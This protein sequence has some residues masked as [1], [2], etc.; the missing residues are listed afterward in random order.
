M[1]NRAITDS[2]SY[3]E[4]RGKQQSVRKVFEFCLERLNAPPKLQTEIL[5]RLG[6]LEARDQRTLRERLR[7][8]E[9]AATAAQHIKVAWVDLGDWRRGLGVDGWIEQLKGDGGLSTLRLPGSVEALERVVRQADKRQ[10]LK[11]KRRIG[12]I[13][14]RSETGRPRGGQQTRVSADDQ[15]R[16]ADQALTLYKALRPVV[17]MR[18]FTSEQK[19]RR[20]ILTLLQSHQ[21]P[22]ADLEVDR[23][24]RTPTRLLRIVDHL[25]A[26]A[27]GVNDIAVTQARRKYGRI[28]VS[29]PDRRR[30]V[31]RKP[32]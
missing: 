12:Q 4:L 1:S 27:A 32:T 10:L 13:A 16:F 21:I 22:K 15:R 17:R 24:L 3:Q 5:M 20:Q 11:L 9:R 7:N 6:V 31:Q 14:R 23:V 25:V 26:H 30:A 19:Q 8:E 29:T 18:T 2:P 28:R